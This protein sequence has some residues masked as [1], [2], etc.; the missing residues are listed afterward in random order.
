MRI[1]LAGPLAEA[2]VLGKPLR[3]LG[4]REDL[5]FCINM[6]GRLN[7]LWAYVSQFTLLAPID[8]EKLM[9]TQRRKTR[10]WLAQPKVWKVIELV[11]KQ[12]SVKGKLNDKELGYL[13]N[14]AGWLN[15]KQSPFR[16]L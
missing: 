5:E 3:S 7:H 8:T 2:K 1:Y 12:L 15:D 11:A 6:S 4:A 9:E 16:F 10:Q 13:I 14:Q